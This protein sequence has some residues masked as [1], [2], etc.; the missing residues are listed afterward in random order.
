[1]K[2]PDDA[3]RR[4]WFFAFAGLAILMGGIDATIIAVALPQLTA[5]LD[6][7][8][9]WVVWTLTAYQLAQ[10]VM[11]PVAGRLSETLGRKRVFLASTLVFVV[12]SLL[13]GL[14]PSIGFLIFFR[15]LQA[16][17]GGGIMPSAVGLVAEQ[18]GRQRAQAIGLFTSLFPVGAVLGPN[19]GGYILQHWGWRELFFVNVPIGILILVGVNVLLR[20]DRPSERRLHVDFVGIGLF[21]GALLAL[22]YGMTELG[23]DVGLLRSPW[24]W[25]LFAA[26][27]VLGALFLRHV[28]VAPEPVVPFHLLARN[29]FLA[30]NLYNFFYGV[31][32]FGFSVFIPYY[33]VVK[34]GMTAFE[35]GAVMTPRALAMALVS[36][37]AS[38]T[39]M[40]L[41]YRLPMVGGALVVAFSLLLMAQGW[42]G[43][44]VDGLTL[45]G[46]WV[47]ALVLALNGAGTGVG[48]PASSNAG[49]DLAPKEAAAISGLRGMFRQAGGVVGIASV[50]LALSFFADKAQGLETIFLALA[51]VML[52]TVP[53]AY[54]IPDTARQR[55]LARRG[56]APALLTHEPSPA[57][58]VAPA[59]APPRPPA[60]APQRPV[61]QPAP[62]PTAAPTATPPRAP[63]AVP[64]RHSPAPVGRVSRPR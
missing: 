11:M 18:F 33:A 54:L 24:L 9:T 62:A 42:S 6:A 23:N 3:S 16:L 39:I 48:A 49:I 26:S 47:L 45:G 63:L 37:L 53:L 32:A 43:F 57:P 29:P 30:A 10:L 20:G 28:R 2:P 64:A 38:V 58:T 55:W 52:V 14:A 7:P 27:L 44:Q 50:T 12:G 51:A 1:V 8:L 22:M 19:L 56:A 34:Y 5:S 46:F 15:V 31:A 59:P 41:G 36:A 61:D 4:Y 17:G 60:S 13:C 21:A 25:A 40:R 35:S